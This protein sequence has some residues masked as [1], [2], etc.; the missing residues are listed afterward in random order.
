MDVFH[1]ENEVQRVGGRWL[2]AGNEMEIEIP[3]MLA[4]GVDEKTSTTDRGS[5]FGHPADDV[6][7]QPYAQTVA[8]VT[9]IDTEARQERYGLRISART[10]AETVRRILN[11][12]AGHGPGVVGDNDG[13]VR[14]G[15]YEHL[16]CTGR[17]RLSGVIAQPDGLL[18]RAALELVKRVVRLEQPGP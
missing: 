3:G 12:D 5:E 13:G 18:G 7:E 4:L 6:L 11:S 10:S 1:E 16:G 17:V 8:L 15:D 9:D 2:E 14:L